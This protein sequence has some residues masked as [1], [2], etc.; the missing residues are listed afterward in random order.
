M[1]KS[2]L[3]RTTNVKLEFLLRETSIKLLLLKLTYPSKFLCW[4]KMLHLDYFTSS[5]IILLSHYFT[6]FNYGKGSLDNGY[7]DNLDNEFLNKY[8]K[9]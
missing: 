7:L 2:K 4:S 5:L 9:T 1:H 8:K 3:L 6:Y